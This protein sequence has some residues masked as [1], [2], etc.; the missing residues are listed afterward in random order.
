MRQHVDLAVVGDGI[1]GRSIALAVAERDSDRTVLLV[2][3]AGPGASRAAGAMLGA[4]AEVTTDS[5]RTET[6]RA[7]VELARIASHR[8]AD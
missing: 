4:V 8:W 1:L 7:R 3:R 2:G 6:A 5:L